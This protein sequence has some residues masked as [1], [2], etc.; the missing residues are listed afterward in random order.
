[1]DSPSWQ[2]SSTLVGFGQ[3]FLS[4]EQCD[5]TG[6]SPILSWPGSSFV[7]VPSTEISI[8]GMALLWCYWHCDATDITDNATEKLKRLPIKWLPGMSPTHFQLPAEVYCCTWGKIWRK[9]SLNDC[10]VLFFS[11]I[12]WFWEH[13]EAIICILHSF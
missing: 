8:D 11:E 9:S 10:T 5:N 1:M 3:V 2:C 6:A 12:K 7:P 4:K 13:F